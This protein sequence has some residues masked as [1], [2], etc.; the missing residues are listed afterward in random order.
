[1]ITNCSFRKNNQVITFIQ[2]FLCFAVCL[3]AIALIGPIDSN[4][5]CFK[6][7]I[8][9]RYFTKFHFCHIP[10]VTLRGKHCKRVYRDMKS[11]SDNKCKPVL[12]LTCFDVRSRRVNRKEKKIV[13]CPNSS[14]A[15]SNRIKFWRAEQYNQQ[16]I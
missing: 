8:E 9:Q 4:I 5:N 11:G 14:E 1:M 15:V 3:I 13:K 12:F 16:R 6:K 2:A 10:Y 7:N